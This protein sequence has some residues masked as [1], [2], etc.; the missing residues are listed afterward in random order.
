MHLQPID[1]FGMAIRSQG[2]WIQ[3]MP[4]E[5]RRCIGCHESRTGQGTPRSIPGQTVAE[6]HQADNLVVP[7]DQR[8][9]TRAATD[10]VNV[11]EYGWNVSVQQI[12]KNNK[13]DTCH[14]ATTNGSG[15]QTFYSLTRTDPNTGATTTYN[16]P[17]LDLSDTPI[18]V[19]YDRNVATYPAA[20]VS[21]FYPA[22]MMTTPGTTVTGKVPPLWGVPGSARASALI[23]K[24]NL[25]AQ[26]G[27]TA[28]PTST[29]PLHP[30]D[31]GVQ[32][33]DNDRA[34][35]VRVM[36]LGGQYYARQNTGF[37]PYAKDPVAGAK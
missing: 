7:L 27:S 15:P 21:I 32:M 20:Y 34:I 13:C 11:G 12:F 26:D 23:E 2:L 17:T 14:N 1:K 31:V 10:P 19:V 25:R 22:G 37:L 4:N 30:E 9:K 16:I 35:L 33:S 29:H 18:T 8:Y 28:W 6:Q 5:D 3:G 24:V 36:D